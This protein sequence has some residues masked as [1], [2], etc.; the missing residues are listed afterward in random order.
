[1][2]RVPLPILVP[3]RQAEACNRLSGRLFYQ[4]RK[5][6]R[7]HDFV[8][9]DASRLTAS[10]RR[11]RSAV[12]RSIMSRVEMP[13]GIGGCW[14][15]EGKTVYPTIDIS[16]FVRR[17]RYIPPTTVHRLMLGFRTDC[18]PH[19]LYVSCHRCGNSRCVN[20][21]HLYWGDS[22]S[23]A[24]DT[25][26][27]GQTKA[28]RDRERFRRHAGDAAFGLYLAQRKTARGGYLGPSACGRCVA[29]V[30]GS[31]ADFAALAASPST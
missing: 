23:N 9:R 27:H 31:S 28:A 1:M 5:S 11:V 20:P 22:Q 29:A 25:A 21:R 24:E 16:R 12:L 7:I 8:V 18:Y 15:I 19:F 13:H 2:G 17:G 26:C 10:G 4:D 14:L 3:D 6:Q 30:L